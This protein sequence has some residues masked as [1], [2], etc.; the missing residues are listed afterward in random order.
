MKDSNLKIIF[1]LISAGL[2]ST[3]LYKLSNIPGGMILSGLF[4]GGMLIIGIFIGC[5]F[6]S[7]I[8]KQIF[9]KI[10]FLTLLL[11]TTTVCF[12]V[13]HYKLYSPT[14]TIVVPD[15]YRGQINLVLSNLSENSLAVDS[16]GIGYLTEWTFDKT[17]TR[18]IVKQENGKNLDEYLIGF[19]ISTFFGRSKSCCVGNR[20]IQ[21]LSFK[22]GTKPHL[23]DEYFDS[24][25]I[26]ELVDKDITIFTKLGKH[27]VVQ[28]G[29]ANNN[30]KK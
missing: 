18:P 21:S 30:T 8:L 1:G 6:L 25:S 2:V 17:Y 9:K 7:R 15:G 27:T 10:S 19:N 20:E 12:L 16:N 13:F 5:L 23:E 29:A 26:T 11:I 4:L 24:R 28:T 22:I 14:L 3:L